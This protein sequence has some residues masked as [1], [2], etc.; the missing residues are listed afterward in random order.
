MKMITERQIAQAETDI[1]ASI[2]T[3]STKAPEIQ[4]VAQLRRSDLSYTPATVL[5]PPPSAYTS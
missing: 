1:Q 5:P 4:V 2:I 3:M